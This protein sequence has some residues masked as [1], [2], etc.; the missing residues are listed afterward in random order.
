M[1]VGRLKSDPG[2]WTEVVLSFPL[3]LVGD[4]AMAPP[5]SNMFL[6]A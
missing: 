5:H 1:L 2:V 6:P 3:P 4:S